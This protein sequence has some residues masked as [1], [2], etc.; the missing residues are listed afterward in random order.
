MVALPVI[1]IL[2]YILML[3]VA[4]LSRVFK[5][6]DCWKWFRKLLAFD[7]ALAVVCMMVCIGT[8]IVTVLQGEG[9]LL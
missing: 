9:V 4:L 3:V 2:V 6:V 5:N 8:L 7:I 1:A